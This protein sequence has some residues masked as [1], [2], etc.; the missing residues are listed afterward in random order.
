MSKQSHISKSSGFPVREGQDGPAGMVR[1]EGLEPP[2]FSPLVPKTSASTNSATPAPAKRDGNGPWSAPLENAS[3]ASHP[4]RDAA[5]YQFT[6]ALQQKNDGHGSKS[7][8]LPGDAMRQLDHGRARL[9]QDTRG[10][11]LARRV[12]AAMQTLD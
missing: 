4:H 10:F 1:A 11:D 8:R 3:A 6:R 12:A 7:R 5:L 2:R 9:V